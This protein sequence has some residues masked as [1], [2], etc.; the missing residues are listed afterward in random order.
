MNSLC[1][2]GFC[3]VADNDPGTRSHSIQLINKIIIDLIK[4]H[5]AK[6][7]YNVALDYQY[8]FSHLYVR[9]LL[10]AIKNN[11]RFFS[12]NGQ[13]QNGSCFMPQSFNESVFQRCSRLRLFFF[14]EI[15]ITS[16]GNRIL[17]FLSLLLLFCNEAQTGAFILFIELY[18]QNVILHHYFV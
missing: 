7:N 18:E 9:L 10:Q 11:R 4:L 14:N 15:E 3:I 16:I 13:P 2:M 12:A 6:N 1:S 8:F 17:L 5:V